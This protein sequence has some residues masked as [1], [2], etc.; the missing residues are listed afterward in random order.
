M[1]LRS[2]LAAG[3]ILGLAVGLHAAFHGLGNELPRLFPHL[4]R[5]V[6]VA[7]PPT[8]SDAASA[9]A[10]EDLPVGEEDPGPPSA[11]APIKHSGEVSELD[12]IPS[13][14]DLASLSP[15]RKLLSPSRLPD[16]TRGARPVSE[17]FEVT[18]ALVPVVDFWKKVYAVYDSDHVVLH[19][20]D[21]LEI[22]YGVL[23]FSDL[24]RKNLSDADKKA[25]HDQGIR[26]A[27]ER[28]QAALTELDEWEGL[29]PL[30][31]EAQS[32]SALFRHVSD[33]DKYKKAK[34]GLR[35]QSGLKDRFAQAIQRSGRYM[36][37]F[38]EVF[39]YYGVPKE[40]TRL[41]FVESMFKERALSKV[42]AAGL[43]QF[44]ADS[45]TKYMT[46]DPNLDERYDPMVATHGAA[47]LLLRNYDLL[48]TW[49]LAINAY[50]SGP[51][52]L[53]K[54]IQRLGTKDIGRIVS[55]YRSSSYAF[56][57]RNFYPSFLAAL[58]VYDNQEKYFGRLH[59]ERPWEFDL[60]ELPST[61]SFPEV[62]FLSGASL[63]E[64]KDFNPA[65]SDAVLEGRFSLPAGSQVRLPSG[66]QTTFAAR[67]VQYSTDQV[68]SM[69]TSPTFHVANSGE[70]YA[71]IATRYGIPF[72]DLRR[73]NGQADSGDPQVAPTRGQVLLVPRESDLVQDR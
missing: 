3:L 63:G 72:Q 27:T 28:I 20:M 68:A 41:A 57:S 42:N 36:P 38:E 23:D 65:Y 39:A 71:N 30:S 32:I 25:A 26:E 22:E 18:P 35:T 54:A 14:S 46:V 40:I 29:R 50:N 8:A 59:K 64:L 56:A 37:L 58:D 51:G 48:G 9:G 69:A 4:A 11:A 19:D 6:R 5:E 7:P 52:N 67:F 1:K 70:S 55:E 13:P 66:R 2:A 45:A 43:W 31:A 16:F 47:R 33:P 12:W 15:G 21:H 53:Q 17:H 44:M 73:V 49:P 61:M 62:A 60:V 34:E 10:D 24:D